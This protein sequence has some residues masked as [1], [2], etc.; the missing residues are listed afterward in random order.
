MKQ[1]TMSTDSETR[2]Q[3][4]A[5]R[6]AARNARKLAEATGTPFYVVQDGKIV[7]LNPRGKRRR[8]TA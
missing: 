5:L 8:K 2:G 1:K 7:N 3:L 4:A 6:R